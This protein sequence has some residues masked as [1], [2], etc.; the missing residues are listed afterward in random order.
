MSDQWLL[1]DG[2]VFSTTPRWLLK[3][4]DL[5]YQTSGIILGLSDCLH[6]KNR[7]AVAW[8]DDA[9]YIFRWSC[10]TVLAHRAPKVQAFCSCCSYC[11]PT[12]LLV[13]FIWMTI[14]TVVTINPACD[15]S[16]LQ[17]FPLIVVIL[18]FRHRCLHSL[19]VFSRARG[20]KALLLHT[21]GDD[22]PMVITC[23]LGLCS[24]R[25]ASARGEISGS[26]SLAISCFCTMSLGFHTLRLFFWRLLLLPSITNF[27]TR[28]V[29][30]ELPPV[31]PPIERFPV[32][33]PIFPEASMSYY[34]ESRA[35]EDVPDAES[36]ARVEQILAFPTVARDSNELRDSETGAFK[37]C[38]ICNDDMTGVDTSVLRTSCDHLYHHSCLAEWVR[39]R[40]SC[41]LC[42][43]NLFACPNGQLQWA[44]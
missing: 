38:A 44:A 12:A 18:H 32:V 3:S 22:V 26:L 37:T 34:G 43:Q 19:A 35:P 39:K 33:A 13:S 28:H 23:V 24:V 6:T 8:Y 36:M 5:P 11:F 20:M 1:G 42:R 25:A 29:D 15:P 30:L 4:Q 7:G 16:W 21:L 41:P 40:Y 2:D 9:Q 14:G 27:L 17:L 10:W 31:L